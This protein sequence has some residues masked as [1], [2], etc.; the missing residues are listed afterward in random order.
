MNWLRAQFRRWLGIDKLEMRVLDIERHFV[1]KRN[2]EGQ[3]VETLAD[4]PVEQRK[5]KSVSTRGM[6]MAQRIAWAERT[7]GGRMV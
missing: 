6:S 1:T 7:D 5:L 4:V 3:P 2:A